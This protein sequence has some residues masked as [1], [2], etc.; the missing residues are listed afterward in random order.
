M[1]PFLPTPY[2][3]LVDR[4]PKQPESPSTFR[5]I[6]FAIVT[7]RICW[8]P[9]PICG[10]FRFYWDTP[11]WSTPWF[12]CTCHPNIS[13]RSPIR[14]N[15]L[16]SPASTRSSAP[17]GWRKNDPATLGGG[18]YRSRTRE[19]LHREQSPL[20]SLDAPQSPVRHC[21]VPHCHSGRSPRPV[22]SLRLSCH[23]L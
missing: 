14:L 16:N 11:D 15:R 3:S 5:R 20:D 10:R 21:S 8:K 6:R 4:P 22:F 12:T 1:F 18:R 23:F 7:L 13:R 19:S 17:G 2:G 9:V